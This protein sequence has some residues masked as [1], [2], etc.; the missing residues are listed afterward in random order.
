MKSLLWIFISTVIIVILGFIG[1]ALGAELGS[2]FITAIGFLLFIFIG[3]MIAGRI[4]RARAI[5]GPVIGCIVA[6]I[7]FD[8][9]DSDP[10][11]IVI[12]SVIALVA[13]FLGGLIGSRGQKKTAKPI[14]QSEQPARNDEQGQGPAIADEQM[15]QPLEPEPD[16]QARFCPTCGKPMSYVDKYKAYYCY[17]CDI[18]PDIEAPQ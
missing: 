15:P 12:T 6:L 10:S 11:T 16:G 8:I 13:G 4:A 1:V 17:K 3:S 18:Y 5:I 14:R 9:Q 2:T 7:M